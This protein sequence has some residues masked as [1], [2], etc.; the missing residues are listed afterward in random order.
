[1]INLKEI[2]QDLKEQFTNVCI[3]NDK[4]KTYRRIKITTGG[5]VIKQDQIEKYLNKKYPSLVTFRST[6]S[7]YNGGYYNGVC[8]RLSL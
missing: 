5:N 6:N 8:F 4:R 7:H 3:F 1:M 2:K